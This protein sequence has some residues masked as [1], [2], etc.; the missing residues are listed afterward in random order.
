M[1][2]QESSSTDDHIYLIK[3]NTGEDL[4][5]EV[6]EVE[7]KSGDV[8]VIN[9]CIMTPIFDPE[10]KRPVLALFRWIPSSVFMDTVFDIYTGSIVATAVPP[11]ELIEN[12]KR[13][14]AMSR[15]RSLVQA[16]DKSIANTTYQ[17]FKRILFDGDI[18]E[19]S[20]NT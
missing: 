12:Y 3:L 6:I 18:T 16:P 10:I 15:E 17:N 7:D 2:S 13:Y 1:P 11:K 5:V 20:A 14:V 4:I 9:P 19:R 8:S